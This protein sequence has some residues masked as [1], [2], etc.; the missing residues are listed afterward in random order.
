M[1]EVAGVT[2]TSFFMRIGRRRCMQTGVTWVWMLTGVT[3]RAQPL[4]ANEIILASAAIQSLLNNH[5]LHDILHS[6]RLRSPRRF[7]LPHQ[8]PQR[9]FRNRILTLRILF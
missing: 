6:M 1:K 5:S 8:L 2:A 4:H 7:Q 9:L 3:L